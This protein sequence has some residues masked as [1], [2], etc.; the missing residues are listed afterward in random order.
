MATTQRAMAVLDEFRTAWNM[1]LSGVPLD[2]IAQALGTNVPRVREILKQGDEVVSYARGVEFDLA[3]LRR[4]EMSR[5]DAVMRGHYR[6]ATGTYV[7]EYMRL[8]PRM[9]AD[10]LDDDDERRALMD[11]IERVLPRLILESQRSARVVFQAHDRRAK[12]VGLVEPEVD[13]TTIMPIVIFT[14]PRPARIRT[15]DD[16]SEIMEG[17]I[18]DDEQLE[19]GA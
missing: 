10:V 2:D 12:L 6:M 7:E 18:V 13:P 15:N 9:V 14:A 16:G 5:L 1:Q 17:E 8:L 11:S 4:I 3:E 19:A